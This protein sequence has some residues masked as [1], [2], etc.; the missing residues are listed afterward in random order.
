MLKIPCWWRRC[1]FK[2]DFSS[3]YHNL[4][5]FSVIIWTCSSSIFVQGQSKWIHIMD[6][7]M[8]YLYRSHRTQKLQKFCSICTNHS[9]SACDSWSCCWLSWSL[10]DQYL[11][12]LNFYTRCYSLVIPLCL[13][14]TSKP[15]LEMQNLQDLSNHCWISLTIFMI[16]S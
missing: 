1:D 3:Q 5:Q 16:D 6:I 8:K 15:N 7:C 2:W 11:W 4:Q 14:C 12:F 10:C 13:F 9:H